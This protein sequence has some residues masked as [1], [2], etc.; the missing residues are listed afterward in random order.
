[1]NQDLLWLHVL[2]GT[3]MYAKYVVEGVIPNNQET[4]ETVFQF[5]TEGLSGYLSL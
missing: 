1:M 3:V 4:E 5:L 2:T